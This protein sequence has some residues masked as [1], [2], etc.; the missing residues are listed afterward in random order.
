MYLSDKEAHQGLILTREVEVVERLS[1]LKLGLFW[2]Q[3]VEGEVHHKVVFPEMINKM[4]A[5]SVQGVMV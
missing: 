5:V 4:E 3:V 1:S 2:W